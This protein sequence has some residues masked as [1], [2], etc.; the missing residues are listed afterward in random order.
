MQPLLKCIL[1]AVVMVLFVLAPSTNSLAQSCTPIITFSGQ[2]SVCKNGQLL[3][4]ASEA[5]SYL[6]ST[7]ATTRSIAITSSGSY[8]VT[9]TT[10]GGCTATSQPVQIGSSE[11]EGTTLAPFGTVCTITEPFK[12]SGGQAAGGVYSGT[13]V[14]NGIFDPQV[15]GPG[16]HII[17]YTVPNEGLCSN[18]AAQI[19]Q[20]DPQPDA[21]I[22]DPLYDFTYCSYTGSANSFKLEVENASKT[23]A[24]NT[25]YTISWGD[26]KSDNYGKD[27]ERATH[28]YTA[29]GLYT[30]TVTA[31]DANG[32]V[33]TSTEQMFIGSNPGLG[34]TSD[35]NNIDCAPVSYGFKITGVEGNSPHTVYTFQFDDGT[36]AVT[37]KHTELPADRILRHEFLESSKDK[38]NGFT[39][40]GTAT[41]Q[42]NVSIATFTGIRISKGPIAN[43]AIGNVC[44]GEPVKFQDKTKNGY[45]ASAR[46]DRYRVKW[47]IFPATGWTFSSGNS[48]TL[49]PN[50]VFNKLGEYTVRLTSYPLDPNSTC[51]P[52]VM[53][54]TIVVNDVPKAAFDLTHDG[55][56]CA[57]SIFRAQNKS[58]GTDLRYTWSVS[59][60]EGWSFAEGTDAN[61]ENPVFSFGKSGSYTVSLVASSVCSAVSKQESEVTVIQKPVVTLPE[62]ATYCGPQTVFFSENNPK[63]LPLYDAQAGQISTYTWA[64]SGPGAIAFEEGSD[65]NSAYPTIRFTEPGTYEV[66]VTATNECGDSE[67]ATQL[68]T[69]DAIPELTLKAAKEVVC[70]NSGTMQLEASP[71]GGV[72]SGS[73]LVSEE[74]VFNPAE[75]GTYTLTYTYRAGSCEVSEALQVTVSSLPAAPIAEGIAT[76]L[77]PGSSATLRIIN[78]EG[79]I[80]WYDQPTGGQLLH[81]GDSYTTQALNE[82]S[83]FYA[84]TTVEG[85]CSSVRT[86]VK[87]TLYPPTPAP[88]V[89][90]LTLCGA[91]SS[92]TLVAEGNAGGYEWFADAAATQPLGNNKSYT[93][94]NLPEGINTFYVRAVTNGCYSPIV[95]AQITVLPALDNNRLHEAATVCAGQSPALLSGTSPAGGNNS[96]TYRWEVSVTGETDGFE[97]IAGATAATY[98]PG[99]LTR[100]TWFR[101]AVLSAGCSHVSAPIEVTVTPVVENNIITGI[102]P[103]CEGAEAA[104]LQGSQPTGGT[105]SYTYIWEY[106]TTGNT[107]SFRAASGNN[108]E[109]HYNPGILTQTTWFRRKAK[110]GTCQEHISEAV[111][112]SVVKPIT[113]NFVSVQQNTICSGSTPA[114]IIGSM[115]Q[116][117]N[118]QKT[119]RWEM[120]SEGRDFV[121]AVGNNTGL[122]YTPQ[123]N[124][125]T[126]WYRRVVTGSPCGESVSGEIAITVQPAIA[127]NNIS[128]AGQQIICEGTAAAVLSGS[129]PVGGNNS[130]TYRWLFNTTGPDATFTPAPGANTGQHYTSPTALTQTTWYMREV[131]SGECVQNS[132]VVEVT[133]VNLPTAPTVAPVTVCEGSSATLTVN[134]TTTNTFRWYA[135]ATAERHLFE[136]Y[137][138]ETAPLNE[139]TIFYVEAVNPNGCGSSERRPVTVTVN[140][141]IDRNTLS[142]AVAP[143]CA[144][145]RP[146]IISGSEPTGGNGSFTYRWE[147]SELGPEEGFGTVEGATSASYHPEAL[148]Q[149]TWFRRVVISGP[150]AAH[151]SAAVKISVLPAISNNS[152]STAKATI[153]EGD[154]LQTI[155]GTAPAGGNGSY[156]YLW[157]SSRDGVSFT[158]AAGT[159]HQADYTAPTPLTE[160]TWFRRIV[161]SAPCSQSVSEMLEIVVQP[162]IS[163]NTI[164]TKEHAVCAGEAPAELKATRPTGGNE[165]PVYLWESRTEGQDFEPASGIN[166]GMHYQPGKLTQTTWFRRKVVAG[167]C[168]HVSET[169]RILVNEVIAHNTISADQVICTGSA[170]AKLRGSQPTGGD[171]SYTYY[172]EAAGTDGV[173][174]RL[175]GTSAD[176]STGPLTSTTLYRRVVESGPC[177]HTSNTVTI[178]VSPSI[179]NNTIG[180]QQT[181][182]KG[183]TPAPLSGSNPSGGAG[184][185]SYTYVWESSGSQHTGY[186]LAA[187]INTGRNYSP[188]AMQESTWFRRRVISGGCETVSEPVLI[189][190]H[191]GVVNN[192][193]Y[194]DQVICA[195]NKPSQLKGSLPAGGD[196]SYLYLWLSS[197]KSAK[198]GF[199]TAGGSSTGQDYSPAALTQSTWFRRVVLSGPTPDTSAAV[200]I[201]VR[202]PM[203]NNRVSTSQTICHG[204]APTPLAGTLP[205]G[206][207]GAYTY[208][209]ESST[210]GPDKGYT[211]ATGTNN[212]KDYQPAALTQTTWFRRIVTSES[213]ERLV[214]DPVMI[215]VTTLPAMPIA[216]GQTICHGSKTTLTATGKGGRLEWFTQPNGGVPVKVGDSFTTPVLTSTTTYY[217]QEVALSCASERRP[218][219]VTV[220]APSANAGSD[221]TVVLGRTVQLAASGGKTYTWS[222]AKGLSNPNIAN[223]YA[224]PEE[225]TTYTV[226]VTN[227]A[228]CVSTDEVT[229]TVQQLVY[230]PN[231]FTPNRD[232]INDVWEILNI[233]Q[234]PNCK[235]QVFNQWGNLV[236]SSLGYKLPWD[237]SQNGKELPLATYY[238]VI[239]LDQ[240]E[241][242]LSGSV[243]IVK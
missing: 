49:S 6:W 106:S 213:C 62:A 19:I 42:C 92:A 145:Q 32:C 17:T 237:G 20:V 75:A 15:A 224:K 72:W 3:L 140:K 76:T 218:V 18:S 14:S 153:C 210:S 242:P 222:P 35:G 139:T 122:N 114:V 212:G 158:S 178:T 190:V 119:Y 172:W 152:I 207:S 48:E 143:I 44:L 148:Q 63:H 155:K 113:M 203:A 30:I 125:K 112:V 53:E 183:Q 194:S 39:L 11:S 141:R 60:Q 100:N 184:A 182:F 28:T 216:Q 160:R 225:T 22:I 120:R 126:M 195:G 200:F 196:G 64:V 110:S 157:E 66:Q 12:L 208:V 47:E 61:S 170:P 169:V 165:Q 25:G 10:Q 57:P 239:Q 164:T 56:V 68:I 192:N 90:P 131:I 180:L 147:K 240:H 133:V 111:K 175:N 98:Q 174:R 94:T 51:L 109:Q 154:V 149:N 96:Y 87:V 59:P 159:N 238:Y 95:S 230:V 7:G 177:T 243:T 128:I 185:G 166:N 179:T 191:K 70:L 226:T 173:F 23:A 65:A 101:R 227:E 193:I 52:T 29:A 1:M 124:D 162:V 220:P 117:G 241:K 89:A 83:T 134:S 85:G 223:P 45:D 104:T 97:E 82:T 234:Y 202:P 4:T 93:A 206:G 86:A 67:A 235:V 2:A 233:E 137:S 217:V 73:P 54:Q 186:Q 102:A 176:L 105:G 211:T 232:G 46:T 71:T 84:Q 21:K 236:F 37:Y 78:P 99:A 129:I 16:E 221:Q 205:T 209:W 69:I 116:G 130:Y 132:D 108:T 231:T 168:S 189:E 201:S 144:G 9:T 27:F 26:G 136:G 150:C 33:G 229:I 146:T 204:T 151:T 228:G 38:P 138:F 55:G 198:A 167:E 91:G 123:I 58:T 5:D 121:P 215:T 115:P 199:V 80:T 88:V 127:D 13:G 50:V 79:V 107:G 135:S 118:S 214:S 40:T 181:I 36:P 161:Y 163:N 81:E 197:T 43:F 219:T 103:I 31:T 142:A 34:I 74:G 77:C 156:T 187:G 8:H 41:N 188:G 24:T 171:G